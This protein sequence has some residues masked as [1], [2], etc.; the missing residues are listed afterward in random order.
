[1]KVSLEFGNHIKKMFRKYFGCTDAWDSLLGPELAKESKEPF[2]IV[3]PDQATKS[4][5][6]KL[7][8]WNFLPCFLTHNMMIFFSS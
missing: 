6:S 8:F 7:N 3:A 2:W 1:M 4:I 5:V